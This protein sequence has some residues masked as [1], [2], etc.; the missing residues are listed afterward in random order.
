MHLASLKVCFSIWLKVFKMCAFNGIFAI[1]KWLYASFHRR[2]LLLI[3]I[4]RNQD[5]SFVL[6]RW[7]NQKWCLYL[8]TH[9]T[10]LDIHWEIRRSVLYLIWY[11]LKQQNL[12]ISC[13]MFKSPVTCNLTR[14]VLIPYVPWR[15]AQMSG[16]P[17]VCGRGNVFVVSVCVSV[18][19]C[20]C[21]SVC[22]C[23]CLSICLFRL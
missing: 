13:S 18:C 1:F 6:F 5:C 16:L 23:V 22:L 2:M 10:M 15:N 20:V 17:H 8:M 14:F 12:K 11:T 7:D 3:M 9:Y 4:P 19:L 21:V